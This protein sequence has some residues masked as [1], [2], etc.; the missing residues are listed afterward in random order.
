V[1]VQDQDHSYAP[2]TSSSPTP[3]TSTLTSL[4]DEGLSDS[5][6]RFN[7]D[8]KDPKVLKVAGIAGGIIFVIILLFIFSINAKKVDEEETVVPVATDD[9]FVEEYKFTYTEE[10]RAL[11]RSYGFTGD[12][13]E[14]F[15]FMEEDIAA[16]INK[17]KENREAV[18][19]DEYKAFLRTSN[20]STDEKY[21]YFLANTYLGLKP[22]K[23]N[24]K[25]TVYEYLTITEN[26]DYYKMQLQGYQPTLKV[27]LKNNMVLYFQVSPERYFSLPASGNIV[28]KFDYVKYKGCKFIINVIEVK[29]E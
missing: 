18:F 13:I 23:F 20:E 8:F 27:R 9:L 19:T 22:Q 2:E 12:Q 6:R 1:S 10:E 3:P 17:E 15:E 16:I 5:H 7:I 24:E 14:S 28:L 29:E 25:D 4:L 21:T 11:L 26:A